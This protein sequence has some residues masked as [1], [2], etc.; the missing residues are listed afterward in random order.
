MLNL[1]RIVTQPSRTVLK[2]ILRGVSSSGVQ[3]FNNN[4]SDEVAQQI[5]KVRKLLT[6][7][8][9]F[10]HFGFGFFS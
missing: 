6:F 8:A 1:K 5:I 7:Y 10:F 2:R 9:C 4:E 3:Q